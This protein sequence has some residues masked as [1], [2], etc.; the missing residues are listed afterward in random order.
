MT[1]IAQLMGVSWGALSGSF[2]AP[3]LYGLY[4]KKTSKAAVATSFCFGVA[5]MIL[6]L[7]VSMGLLHLPGAFLG[8]VF[9]NSLY[10]GVFTMLASLIIVPLEDRIDALAAPGLDAAVSK[11]CAAEPAR[12][13]VFDAEKLVYISSAGLR[14]LMKAAKAA[15]KK[16]RVPNVSKDVFDIFET[17]GFTSLLDV[18]EALREVS[19]EGCELIGSGSYGNVY[20]LDDETIAKFYMP[21]IT[22]ETVQQEKATAPKALL[23]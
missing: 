2:L 20:R 4:W 21:T 11:A 9:K 22:L 3:F 8:F 18:Q 15:G 13:P 19:V 10:S 7:A 12:T 23:L 5:M 16:L 14:V 1:F 6:Q 17:T